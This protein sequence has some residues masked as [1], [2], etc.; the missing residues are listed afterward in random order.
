MKQTEI[1]LIP[2]DWEVK[3]IMDI[4]ISSKDSLKIGP[5]GSQLK[6]EYLL[7]NGVYKVFGQENIYSSNFDYCYRF[8][9]KEHFH[10]LQSC[11]L[12]PGDFVISTMG[13]I[14]KCD[15]VPE[16]AGVGIMDSHLVRLRLQNTID[17]T[18]FK[19]FF[20]SDAIQHQII[21]LSVGGIMD[22]LSTGI[23]KKLYVIDFDKRNNNESQKP[24]PM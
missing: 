13:T 7:S 3:N 6:K 12:K 15:V 11:E 9:T 21:A 22:G 4:L 23:I 8:L 19:Y 1:G 5:F 2:D 14:G 16:N 18:Y 20:Q 24:F 10:Q 17:K